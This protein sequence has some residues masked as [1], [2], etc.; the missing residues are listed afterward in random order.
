MKLF[1]YFIFLLFKILIVFKFWKV[2]YYI[3]VRERG[4]QPRLHLLETKPQV[5]NPSSGDTAEHCITIYHQHK[6][7]ADR[8]TQ[9]SLLKTQSAT[10]T[11]V[12]TLLGTKFLQPLGLF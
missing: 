12:Y 5:Y 2:V 7:P 4:H 9:L 3:F 11:A 1:P 10:Y 8:L 6:L